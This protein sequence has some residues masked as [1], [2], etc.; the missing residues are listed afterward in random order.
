M[1]IA[2]A[3]LTAEIARRARSGFPAL[4][5]SVGAAGD[6]HGTYSWAVAIDTQTLCFVVD[7]ASSTS[8]NLSRR[9]RATIQIVGAW[10]ANLL[11]AG[12]VRRVSERIAVAHSPAL[13]AWAMQIDRV[14]DQ[15]WPGVTTSR[16]A[17]RWSP[18]ERV[19]MRRLERAIYAALR[20][21]FEQG[22]IDTHAARASP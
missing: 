12:A 4:V 21:S 7:C 17:Y 14:K 8:A 2:P 9:A 10:G 18:D 20:G 19:R 11:V 3:A 5:L 1:S 16:L 6:A 22:P 15:S 13:E